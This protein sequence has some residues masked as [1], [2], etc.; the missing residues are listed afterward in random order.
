[1]ILMQIWNAW[2]RHA[3]NK[4]PRGQ[5]LFEVRGKYGYIYINICFAY[6]GRPDLPGN[7]L[8]PTIGQVKIL[9]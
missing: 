9:L 7:N 6:L 3:R 5:V 8:G 2:N 4:E 1:M